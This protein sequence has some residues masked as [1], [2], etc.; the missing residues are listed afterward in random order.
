MFCWGLVMTLMGIVSS[1]SG[2]LIARF[3]LGV[4]EVC[5]TIVLRKTSVDIPYRL[6]SFRRQR[7]CSPSGIGGMKFR[8]AWQCSIPLHLYLAHF[9]A[10]SPSE[11]SIWMASLA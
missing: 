9:L 1:Y 8:N 4:A 10:S 6:A 5:E 7:F 2:L 11:S 3:F